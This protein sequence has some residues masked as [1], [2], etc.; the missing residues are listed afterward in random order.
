[1]TNIPWSALLALVVATAVLAPSMAH[2]EKAQ[3]VVCKVMKGESEEEEAKAWRTHDGVRYAL[4]SQKCAQ[5]FDVDPLAY[6]TPSLPRPAP[7]LSVADLQGTL[8]TW[9]G[10]KGKVVLLDFWATW[11]APCRKSMPELQ[12]LHD[13]YGSRGFSVVGISIDEGRDAARKVKKFVDAK[14]ITYPI[15]IHAGKTPAWER[16]HVRAV[17]AAFL[18]DQEG[19]IVAQWTGIAA[20]AGQLEKQLDSLL[21]GAR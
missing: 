16:F 7:E 5:E 14:K 18:V 13:R 21:A 19:R 10:M 1:M 20:D 15:G 8:L 4:C 17:P 3:C 2:A 6:V 12:A 9:E 11:C